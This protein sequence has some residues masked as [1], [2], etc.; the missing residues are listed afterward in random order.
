MTE[1][2]ARP[3][4]SVTLPTDNPSEPYLCLTSVGA[5]VPVFSHFHNWQ[6]EI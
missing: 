4:W 5:E 2:P 6:P 3:L 1:P